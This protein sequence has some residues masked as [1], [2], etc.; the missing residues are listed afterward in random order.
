MDSIFIQEIA[1]DPH[2]YYYCIVTHYACF[3][4]EHIKAKMMGLRVIGDTYD[5][6]NLIMSHKFVQNTIHH[7]LEVRITNGTETLA[8]VP[9]FS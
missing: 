3:T 8:D 4:K 5:M 6:E 9:T 7:D 2:E 1:A